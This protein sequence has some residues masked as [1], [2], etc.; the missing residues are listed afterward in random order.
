VSAGWLIVGLVEEAEA[1]FGI[2][3]NSGWKG[4]VRT[5]L[6]VRSRFMRSMKCVRRRSGEKKDFRETQDMQ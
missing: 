4:D 5:V 2:Y 3:T 1:G 6:L